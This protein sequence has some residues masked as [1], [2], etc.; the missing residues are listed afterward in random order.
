MS[1]FSFLKKRKQTSRE[2][3]PVEIQSIPTVKLDRSLVTKA[4]EDD[5][6]ST[7]ASIDDIPRSMKAGLYKEALN[8]APQRDLFSL[9]QYIVSLR[10]NNMS[11]ARAAE[12]SGFIANRTTASVTREHQL[13]L[14]ITEAI[15]I[16]TGAPCG[17]G[18][19]FA[20]DAEHRAA[21]GQKYS[22]RTGMLVNGSYV[23]PGADVGCKCISRSTTE[24]F[25]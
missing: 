20:I 1:L 16:H 19:E 4:V 7:I 18:P 23:W 22:V 15:W 10:L 3:P 12:I 21:N 24:G 9:T 11:R 5:L 6:K 17:V 13:S 14:G 8:S 2:E 25:S